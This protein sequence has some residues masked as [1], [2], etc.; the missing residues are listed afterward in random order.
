MI[1][2]Y[3]CPSCQG[4]GCPN[5]NNVGFFGRDETYDYYLSRGPGGDVVVAGIK[6]G[7]SSKNLLGQF[8]SFFFRI[9]AKQLEEPRDFIW[10]VK[11]R[12][13]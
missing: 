6:Q 7:E 3:P 9:I 11:Q 1:K 12:R 13:K 4:A 5:C 2:P 10:A 8:T